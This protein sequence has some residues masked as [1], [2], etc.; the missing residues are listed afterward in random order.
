VIVR[1]WTRGE[2]NLLFRITTEIW[3]SKHIELLITLLF[4]TSSNTSMRPR[5][6]KL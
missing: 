3:L 5:I 4:E 1:C 6:T 2:N